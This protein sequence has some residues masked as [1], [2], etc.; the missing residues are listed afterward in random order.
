MPP[1]WELAV[2]SINL[3][4]RSSA[5]GW[6]PNCQDSLASPRRL[7][8]KNAQDAKRTRCIPAVCV[9][10]SKQHMAVNSENL[11]TARQRT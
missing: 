1:D 11:H 10:Q 3:L 6:S 4:T 7:S 5:V 8:G 9:T 2:E